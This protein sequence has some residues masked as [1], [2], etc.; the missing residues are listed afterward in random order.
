MEIRHQVRDERGAERWPVLI[1]V[2]LRTDDGSNLSAKVTDISANGLRLKT[3]HSLE[4]G[5]RVFISIPLLGEAPATIVWNAKDT[6]GVVFDRPLPY[7]Q[8]DELV[9]RYPPSFRR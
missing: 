5:K 6:Y 2:S 8:L 7:R 4:A 9:L 1:N 3:Y